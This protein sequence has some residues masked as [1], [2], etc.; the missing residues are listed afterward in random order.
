MRFFPFGSSSL[1]PIFNVTLSTTASIT[2]YAAT[3]SYA[4]RIVSASHALSGSAGVNGANGV[5]VYATGPN[6]PTGDVGDGGLPGTTSNP[7][8]YFP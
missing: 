2:Q 3:A 8:P 5:C 6:G 1:N 7:L 4:I